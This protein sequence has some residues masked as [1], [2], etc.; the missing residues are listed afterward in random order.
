M[1]S[2]NQK[3]KENDYYIVYSFEHNAWWKRNHFGYS[4]DIKAAGVYSYDEAKNI[5][6]KAN[7][8][9]HPAMPNDYSRVTINEAMIPITK[10][11]ASYLRSQPPSLV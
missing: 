5:C 2:K 1:D 10:E 7:M 4:R 6:I 9:G 11:L 3:E 8:L